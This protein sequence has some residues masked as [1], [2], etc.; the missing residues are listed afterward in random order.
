MHENP[1]SQAANVDALATGDS[2][3]DR[4]LVAVTDDLITRSVLLID[5]KQQAMPGKGWILRDQG[6]EDLI[7]ARIA[8]RFDFEFARTRDVGGRSKE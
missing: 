5:R 8:R 3:E 6:R 2:G 1:T 7:A 4:K